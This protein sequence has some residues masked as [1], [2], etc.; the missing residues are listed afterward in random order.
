MTTLAS[1]KSNGSQA[2]RSPDPRPIHNRPL[3][4]AYRL[5]EIRW[6]PVVDGNRACAVRRRSGRRLRGRVAGRLDERGDRPKFEYVTGVSTGALL[7]PIAF[8]GPDYYA[9]LRDLFPTVDEDSLLRERW[10]GVAL[11]EDAVLTP[12]RFSRRSR[13]SSIRTWLLTS[14]AYMQTDGSC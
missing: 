2:D 5:P 4:A 14:N 9:R 1:N 12:R 7:A 13:P 6:P 10:F 11:T 8:L 3:D